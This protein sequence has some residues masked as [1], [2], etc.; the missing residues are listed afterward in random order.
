[1][2]RKVCF[3]KHPFENHQVLLKLT[4]VNDS[5]NESASTHLDKCAIYYIKLNICFDL[6]FFSSVTETFFA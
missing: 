1:M 6:V 3:R 4:S 5:M 2:R